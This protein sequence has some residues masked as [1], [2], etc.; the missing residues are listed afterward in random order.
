[1]SGKFYYVVVSF[2]GSVSGAGGVYGTEAE[3]R[4]KLA[5]ASHDTAT[6]G[7]YWTDPAVLASAR[8]YRYTTRRAARTAD[9]SDKGA[10]V[11]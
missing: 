8:V 4:E 2:G 1:M 9:I 7:R 10:A 6:S 11:V 3:A 5:R